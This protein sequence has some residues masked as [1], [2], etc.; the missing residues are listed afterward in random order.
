VPNVRQ[1]EE[2]L[3]AGA[4]HALLAVW[5]VSLAEALLA[6]AARRARTL[7]AARR[8]CMGDVVYDR[9]AGRVWCASREVSFTPRELRV[10]DCLWWHAGTVVNPETLLS[11]ARKG[12]EST[13]ASNLVQVCVGLVRRKL[14]ESSRVMIIT[15]RSCGYML[16]V[17]DEGGC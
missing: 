9:E 7:N 14:A 10:F 3:N 6:A 8:V 12:S 2:L 1:A 11:H 5:P 15:T 16:C 17:R 4:D 13:N